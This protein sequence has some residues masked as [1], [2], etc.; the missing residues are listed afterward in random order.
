V[1]NTN[2]GLP[3][4]LH[5]FRDIAFDMSKIAVF[6]FCYT[7]AFKALDGGFPTSYTIV[8]D[9]S[10]KLE[11]LGYISVAESFGTPSVTL[12]SA[13]ESYRIR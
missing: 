5:R 13:P 10:L 2:L 3:P 7:V 12:R 6:Q 4:I 1:I 11:A 8:S 9:I